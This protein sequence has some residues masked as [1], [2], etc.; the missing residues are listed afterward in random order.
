MVQHRATSSARVADMHR[1]TAKQQA[2]AIR[3][4]RLVRVVPETVLKA[5]RILSSEDFPREA[6]A[7]ETLK[8]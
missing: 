3:D 7:T 5:D 8:K 4:R 2:M 1:V 6:S